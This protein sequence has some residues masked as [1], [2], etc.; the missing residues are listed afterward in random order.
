LIGNGKGE[1]IFNQVHCETQSIWG[2]E[3]M[4]DGERT[5]FSGYP[6][7]GLVVHEME[8]R[9]GGKVRVFRSYEKWSDAVFSG[10]NNCAFVSRGTRDVRVFREQKEGVTNEKAV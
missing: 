6:F 5:K 2:G 8:E 9:A 1:R 4:K 7:R 10:E 3:L